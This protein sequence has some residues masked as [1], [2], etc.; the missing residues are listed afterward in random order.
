MYSYDP[1]HKKQV[2]KMSRNKIFILLSSVLLLLACSLPA[3]AVAP[4]ANIEQTVNAVRTESALTAIAAE[5]NQ[6]SGTLVPASETLAPSMT[7][8]PSRTPHPSLT[9]VPTNTHIPTLTTTATVTRTATR[10]QLPGGNPKITI[11][12][13][14]KNKAVSVKAENFPPNQIFTIRIGLFN[15]FNN[16]KKVV[17]SIA[18]GN[19]GTLYFTSMIPSEFEDADRF[20]IRLDSNHGYY[21]FNAFENISFGTITYTATPKPTYKCEVETSPSAYTEFALGAD[22]DATWEIKNT[23][24]DDWEKAS[25]DYKYLS[26][27]EMQKY[28]KAYDLP[29]TVASDGTITIVID[30]VAPNTAGTYTT[31]WAIVNG[32]TVLC[33]LPL[34]IKVK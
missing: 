26:G 3:A 5:D 27:T 1:T 8:A 34:T 2:M 18:T 31:T 15:D 9:N 29:N 6:D 4:T 23:S 25:V 22:F 30:M 17:G 14:E 32:D 7:T 24:D 33:K 11:L 10:T 13:V 16:T 21:A 19:G 12:A 28:E 20:T